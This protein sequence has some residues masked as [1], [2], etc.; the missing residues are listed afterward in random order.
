MCVYSPHRVI[1]KLMLF[2]REN[3]KMKKYNIINYR[4]KASVKPI[5]VL[6]EIERLIQI[7][8]VHYSECF[9]KLEALI[10]E[11]EH[12]GKLHSN[13]NK[14][15]I[16]AILKHYPELTCFFE[17][18]KHMDE[19]G[20]VAER[21]RIQNFAEETF[22]PY[23]HVEYSLI[24]QIA[25]KTPRPYSLHDFQVI[26]SG[27]KFGEGSDQQD[28]VKP[29]SNGVDAPVGHYIAYWRSNYGS[30]KHAYMHFSVD[31]DNL[32]SMRSFFFEF[33]K[34]IGGKYVGTEYHT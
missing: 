17:Q 5:D 6:R 15:A 8:D 1:E 14:N 28:N 2:Y 4:L 3:E 20:F 16:L 23:G 31:D 24:R 18:E 34:N 9:I 12:E 30:E 27:I 33:A 10:I 11:M 22:L 13:R 19:N 21:L 7:Y 29:S 32:E 25:E 26:F